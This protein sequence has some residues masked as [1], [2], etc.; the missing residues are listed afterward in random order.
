MV[1]ANMHEE[2]LF[3]SL[4]PGDIN[5]LSCINLCQQGMGLKLGQFNIVGFL[6]NQM[7][8][9][10]ASCLG[11]LNLGGWHHV[12]IFFLDGIREQGQTNQTNILNG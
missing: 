4:V 5:Q 12:D 10:R 7:P 6:G 3:I 8:F 11:S 1:V 9:P 2:S